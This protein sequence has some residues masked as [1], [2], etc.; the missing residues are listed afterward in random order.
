MSDQPAPR[1]LAVTW[2]PEA[3]TD[4]RAI[5]RT[6]VL[7]ILHCADRFLINANGDLKKL[8]PPLTGFR[9][10]CGDYRIFFDF[11]GEN[12]IGITAV[13]HRSAAYR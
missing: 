9:L 11:H 1:R 3:R 10:R 6:T 8:R 4:L 13:R 5:D 12:G 7:D 2:S